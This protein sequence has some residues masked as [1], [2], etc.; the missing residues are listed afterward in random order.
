MERRRL[1]IL[2][3]VCGLAPCFSPAA[4]YKQDR[5]PADARGFKDA[6]RDRIPSPASRMVRAACKRN[7]SS[8][9]P[10]SFDPAALCQN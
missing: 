9:A 7:C 4:G 6:N 10:T 5:A 3:L 8:R 2:L 1:E